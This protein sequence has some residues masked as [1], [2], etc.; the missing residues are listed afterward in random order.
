MS[1][2][3]PLDRAATRR[4]LTQAPLDVLIIGGGIVGAGLARDAALR[5][6]RVGLVEQY[7]FAFGTSS[8][9]TRLLHGGLRYLAQG[10]I[11]LVRQASIEKRVI[12]AIAPHLALPLGFIFPTYRGRPWAPWARWKLRIGVR[13]YDWLCG[14]RNLGRSCG[15]T[16]EQVLALLPGARSEGLTGGVRYYDGLTQ[17]ARLV[18]DTLRSAAGAGALLMNYCRFRDTEFVGGLWCCRVEDRLSST[19]ATG[20]PDSS[21][22]AEVFHLRAR[23]VVNAAGPWGDRVG[24]TSVRLRLTKGVHLVID[25]QRLAIPEAV[26]MT[27]GRR[28]LFAIPW[29][30]RVILGTTDTDY[31]GRVEDVR[32]EP[33]DVREVLGVVNGLFPRAELTE[34]DVIS[35]WAGLRP[36][37]ANANGG[38]SDISRAHEIRSPRPG[39]WDVTGGKLTTYRLMAE[40]TLDRIEAALGRPVS[41]CRT[42]TTPLL[43]PEETAGVSGIIPPALSRAVVEHYCRR[44]WAVHLDD[45][46]LRRTGWHYYE[47]RAER[48]AER[49]T[50]WMGDV[51]G[52]NDAVRTGEMERYLGRGAA[53]CTA[54]GRE[55]QSQR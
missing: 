7:D 22:P 17:D 13:M 10:R 32:T 30:Q 39:W 4:E 16:A 9:S 25:R 52:W 53:F 47:P 20:L 46:M 19:A 41:A 5:G 44:E 11:G 12:H 37:V 40:Q 38:P 15:L 55:V 26:V 50:A 24:P 33:A 21:A 42:A 34:A 54:G 23:V 14:G 28:I 6:L 18:I 48:I 36:L 43:D 3:T 27:Q 35:T 2:P 29:G 45:V 1:R 31:H 51:L 8:R 49:V